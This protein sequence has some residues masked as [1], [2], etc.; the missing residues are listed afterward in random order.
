M[1]Q[2]VKLKDYDGVVQTYEDIS[3]IQIPKSGTGTTPATFKEGIQKSIAITSPTPGTVAPTSEDGNVYFSQVALTIPDASKIIAENIKKDVEILGV[4]GT[5]EPGE[6]PSSFSITYQITDGHVNTD[7]PSSVEIQGSFSCTI[8][9]DNSPDPSFLHPSE[10]LVTGASS[11]LYDPSTGICSVSQIY[12]DVIITATCKT[13]EGLY[14]IY[15]FDVLG[16][17]IVSSKQYIA[18]GQTAEVTFIP[19]ENYAYPRPL[20]FIVAGWCEYEVIEEVDVPAGGYKGV[21][22]IRIYNPEGNISVSATF[23]YAYRISTTKKSG[24]GTISLDKDA[25]ISGNVAEVSFAPAQDYAYPSESDLTI[26]GASYDIVAGS[27]EAIER[28]E[29]S[30]PTSQISIVVDFPYTPSWPKPTI[31]ITGS[32]L[33]TD[34]VADVTQYLIY[35]NDSANPVGYFTRE[36]DYIPLLTN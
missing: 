31:E 34:E 13:A 17:D 32:N 21:K 3:E 18:P 25:I 4:T 16:G 27:E 30:S 19:S 24:E 2:N 36:G 12:D 14:T 20:E 23:R 35:I 1:A 29:V 10:V 7:A 11:V 33:I 22:K 15:T 5:L 9:A 8:T 26:S 6:V 28:I